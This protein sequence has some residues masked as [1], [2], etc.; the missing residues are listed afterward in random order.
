MALKVKNPIILSF[1][2]KAVE[3]VKEKFKKIYREKSKNIYSD[4]EEERTL[5]T[6]LTKNAMHLTHISVIIMVEVYLTLRAR[7]YSLRSTAWFPING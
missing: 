4:D 3:N 5:M 7:Q 6:V 2:N 1:T